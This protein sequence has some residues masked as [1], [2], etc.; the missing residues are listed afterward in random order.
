MHN[1]EKA[2]V[3]DLSLMYINDFDY[4]GDFGLALV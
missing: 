4:E 2:Q 3:T 1:R